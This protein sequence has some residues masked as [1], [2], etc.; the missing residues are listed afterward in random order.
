MKIIIINKLNN[1]KNNKLINLIKKIGINPIITNNYKKIKNSDKLIIS[2]IYNIK[3]TINIINKYKINNIIKIYDKP[4]LSI[5]NGLYILC[6]EYKNLKLLNIFDNIIVKKIYSYK[7]KKFIKNIGFKIN[8]HNNKDK[9]LY[10]IKKKYYQYYNNNKYIDIGAYCIS[11]TNYIKTY[12][13]ILKKN[14]I[15]GLLFY[16]QYSG[17]L[18]EKIIYNFI[19][20]II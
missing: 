10:N 13:A 8:Y 9:I 3:K 18:G 11:H 1:N 19:N 12:S 4:I 16:P 5:V 7:Y 6:K 2:S 20:K 17:K 15:Y 14:N